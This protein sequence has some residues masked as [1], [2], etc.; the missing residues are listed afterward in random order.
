EIASAI[1]VYEHDD[2]GEDE[3]DELDDEDELPSGAGE[4]GETSDAGSKGG[5]PAEMAISLLW[6]EDGEESDAFP[7][8]LRTR[9]GAVAK[10]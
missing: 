5:K 4:T 10:S 2:E 6:E 8:P 1:E 9:K 3:L 7:L